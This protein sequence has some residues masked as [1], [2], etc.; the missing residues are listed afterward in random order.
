VRRAREGRRAGREALMVSGCSGGDRA[1]ASDPP[2]R[3]RHSPCPS[4]PSTKQR[5]PVRGRTSPSSKRRC[6]S[7]DTTA[8]SP[9]GAPATPSRCTGSGSGAAPT[10]RPSTG[11]SARSAPCSGWANATSS[12]HELPPVVEALAAPRRGGTDRATHPSLAGRVTRVALQ[13]GRCQRR[14]GN[15][16]IPWQW[17][18]RAGTWQPVS[19][20]RCW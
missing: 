12:S 10:S 5:G 3:R 17:R 18:R 1:L 4:T 9:C 13:Q 16:A 11:S 19:P 20:H 15:H 6:T 2:G 7:S 14:H 8:S